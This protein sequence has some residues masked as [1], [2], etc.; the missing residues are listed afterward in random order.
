MLWLSR[1][2]ITKASCAVHRAA[3]FSVVCRPALAADAHAIELRHQARL[4]AGS[5]VPMDDALAC[6][7]VK[8]ADR[9]HYRLGS[10]LCLLPHDHALCTL[11]KRLERRAH[12][13][14][15]RAL[16]YARPDPL[17]CKLRIRQLR[18][19]PL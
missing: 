19:P 1:C 12:R 15:A 5:L 2:A 7:L 18:M 4:A 9:A 8:L 10:S 13:L 16:A 3:C 11:D 17:E 6:R 14:I